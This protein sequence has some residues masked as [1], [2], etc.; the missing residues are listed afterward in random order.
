VDPTVAPK[1]NLELYE[2]M[3]DLLQKEEASKQAIR[4]AEVEVIK[5]WQLLLLLSSQLFI[6]VFSYFETAE[7]FRFTEET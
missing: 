7:V 6:A 1:R 2:M 3:I 5:G 4:Q